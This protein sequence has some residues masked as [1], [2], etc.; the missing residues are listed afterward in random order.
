MK[1]TITSTCSTTGVKLVSRHCKE[2]ALDEMTKTVISE[3][4]G[5]TGSADYTITITDKINF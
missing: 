4:E 1:K 5:I 3:T 2:S